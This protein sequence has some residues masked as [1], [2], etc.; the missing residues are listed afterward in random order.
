MSIFSRLFGDKPNIQNDKIEIKEKLIS[1]RAKENTFNISFFKDESNGKFTF[2]KYSKIKSI[3]KIIDTT[4]YKEDLALNKEDLL[5]YT[6]EDF[7]NDYS[8]LGPDIDIED[9]MSL[10][11]KR[12]LN[13]LPI[14]PKLKGQNNVIE[15]ILNS[16]EKNNPVYL[17]A[18]IQIQLEKFDFIEKVDLDRN[19]YIIFICNNLRSTDLESL[20]SEN[21]IKKSNTKP[22][23]VEKLLD[24]NV[25]LPK[26]FKITHKFVNYINELSKLYI[27]DIENSLK[28]IHP[29]FHWSIWNAAYDVNHYPQL[30]AE[31]NKKLE[32]KKWDDLLEPK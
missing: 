13:G 5:N 10:F 26:A 32:E 21:N 27:T 14:I 12:E 15:D 29:L 24:S 11:N 20:C 17:T 28:I 22:K 30:V 3:V 4:N 18:D 2:P 23:T 7:E 31:I 19:S 8:F 6:F 16:I 9:F 25:N 1:K